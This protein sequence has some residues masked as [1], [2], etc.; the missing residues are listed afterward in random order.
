M[1]Y[2]DQYKLYRQ[3][4]VHL[5]TKILEAYV[6]ETEFKQAAGLIGILNNRNQVVIETEA[7]HDALCDFNI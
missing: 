7:D 4:Q 6:H 1:S 5:H 3:T 2:I